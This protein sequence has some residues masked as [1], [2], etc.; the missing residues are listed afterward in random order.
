MKGGRTEPTE[1]VHVAA[2]ALDVD[3]ALLLEA[4]VLELSAANTL[5]S[6]KTVV[7]NRVPVEKN[8]ANF[9]I[10]SEKPQ[11]LLKREEGPG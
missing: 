6:T 10:G 2:G 3:E 5:P 9:S 7:N 11:E 4:V 8:I 1:T